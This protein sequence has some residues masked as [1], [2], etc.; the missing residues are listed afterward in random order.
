MIISNK[1]SKIWF[2]ENKFKKNRF[3]K[4]NECMRVGSEVW[5]DGNTANI[6]GCKTPGS[7]GEISNK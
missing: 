3:L 5:D 2:K 1:A 4:K 7:D 6:N